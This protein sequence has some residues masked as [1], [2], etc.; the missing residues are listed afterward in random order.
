MGMEAVSQLMCL[1]LICSWEPTTYCVEDQ[2]RFFRMP[3]QRI[4][5]LRKRAGY[6]QEDMI[7]HGFS[8]CHWQ[9]IEGWP[10][11]HRQHP[12]SHLPGL[13]LP[14]APPRQGLDAWICRNII[15]AE[16]RIW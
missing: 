10:P 14:D 1:W 3:G 4:R 13:P 7:S 2:D 8:G 12:A 15:S 11:H 9:Q 5:Q 6:S 16:Y